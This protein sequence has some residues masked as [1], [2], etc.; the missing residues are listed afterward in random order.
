M[1]FSAEEKKEAINTDNP[2][3]RKIEKQSLTGHDY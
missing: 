2:V 1:A 3:E